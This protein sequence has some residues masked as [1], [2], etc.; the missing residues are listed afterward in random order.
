MIDHPKAN[1]TSPSDSGGSGGSA[2]AGYEYQIDVSV[3]L[4][5]DLL[6]AN[7]LAQELILEPSSEE[8]LEADLSGHRP[9]R[10]TSALAMD[11]YRLVVQ[12]KQRSSDAWSVNAIRALLKHGSDGRASAAKRLSSPEIRYLLVTTTGLNGGTRGLSVRHAGAWPKAA[13]MPISIAKALPSGAAGRVAVIGNQDDERLMTNIRALLTQNFRVP[14]ARWEEC[15][16][17]LREEARIR[18]RGGDYGRWARTDLEDVIRAHDGY[19]AS[20][21]E[22]EHYV[23]PT[24]WH[25]LSSAMLERNAAIIIGQ[26][27]TG[28]TL[29]TRKIYE[30]LRER[31]PG[32]SRVLITLGPQQLHADQTAPPVLYDIEDPWGRFDFDPRSRPWNDQLANFLS[33]ATHDR[34][35]IA[36]SRLDVAHSSGAL[37]TVTP[38]IV[39]LEAEHYGKNERRRLYGTRI[40]GLPRVLQRVASDAEKSVLDKLGT[41]LEIQKFFDAMATLARDELKNERKFVADAISKAHQ[42]SI[43]RTVI[44]Q[45]EERNDI[46]AATVI[47]ALLKANSRISLSTLRNIEEALAD[48]SA[49]FDEGVAPLIASFVAARNLRQNEDI[50]T[51]YHPR[52]ESGIQQALAAHPLATRKALKLLVEVLTCGD[53]PDQAWGS[54][55]AVRLVAAVA[56]MPEIKPSPSTAS[57]DLMDAWLGENTKTSE[58][59]LGK[60]LQLAG[61]AGSERSTVSELARFLYE[62]PEEGLLGWSYWRVP[63]R[64]EAWYERL[65]SDPTTT[66]LLDAFIRRVLP[67]AR[68]RYPRSF[69]ADIKPLTPSLSLTEAFLAAASEVVYFGVIDS[70]DSIAEGALQDIGR[71][72]TIVDA[73][74]RARLLDEDAK[75]QVEREHLAIT[76]GEY[77][78]EYAEHLSNNDDGYTAGE[79]LEAYVSRIRNDF[80]WRTI[81]EHRHASDLLYYWLRDLAISAKDSPIDLLELEGAAQAAYGTAYEHM[82]WKIVLEQWHAFYLGLLTNRI[83]MGSEHADAREAALACLAVHAPQ[84]LKSIVDRFAE[85]QDHTSITSMTVDLAALTKPHGWFA[86]DAPRSQVVN[87]VIENLPAPFDEIGNAAVSLGSKDAPSLSSDALRMLQGVSGGTGELRRF[88]LALDQKYSLP[89]EEDIRWLLANT[90]NDRVAAEAVNAAARHCMTVELESALHHR[91]ARASAHALKALAESMSA[92]L[93]AS[94]LQMAEA[95]GSFVRQA[96][97]ETLDSKPHHGHLSALLRLAKDSWSSAWTSHGETS[98]F[99]IA[100]SAID[101]IVKLGTLAT[102][103]VKDLRKIAIE[104]SDP[105]LRYKILGAIAKLADNQARDDLFDLAVRP[106]RLQIRRDAAYA[107]LQ[108]SADVSPALLARITAETLIKQN[109]NIATS[110]TLLLA[111]RADPQ[112]VVQMASEI[113]THNRR[114]VLVLLMTWLMNG[115]DA[116]TAE[117]MA[118]LLPSGHIA[119]KFALGDETIVL[120]DQSLADLGD[121]M[122]VAEVLRYAGK[123]QQKK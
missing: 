90:D 76:N 41:P 52:V 70:G 93:P 101:S 43:E 78:D 92:P 63:D 22:L 24:N 88:R 68:I 58:T 48:R 38:W 9:G 55:V 86:D 67:T 121:P 20:S 87:A 19:I 8:D 57:Q 103:T 59:D 112:T 47:W 99:P 117:Q 74:V 102:D 106:G 35:I 64:D 83:A 82:A 42:D 60:H 54:G 65:R 44:E 96:L 114:R 33:H 97:V 17:A 2:L 77:S 39:S 61:A 62:R 16:K 5:L 80:S 45:I 37:K 31:I 109:E 100:Q 110:L 85:L 10:V 79:F 81:A 113:A 115:R 4:A 111:W 36:T 26:S 25:D 71:S 107:L 12:V 104:T 18:I 119:T 13:D 49:H 91:F 122:I 27:G 72:E 69:S 120:E 66:T 98:H 40:N 51:Y 11:G 94:I 7:K 53:G 28:K 34:M 32:L 50:V 123:K 1:P 46:P 21:P 108:A 95:K 3:W 105:A 6:L 30:E 56:G 73:A 14:N 116:D 29:A 89:V 84:Q 23:H 75:Q 118:K 15:H